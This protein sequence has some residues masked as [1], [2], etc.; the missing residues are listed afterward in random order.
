MPR[1]I[2]SGEVEERQGP[3]LAFLRLL[4][5]ADSA[6]PIGAVPHS[7]GLETLVGAGLLTPARVPAF[8]ETYLEESGVMEAVFCRQAFRLAAAT[9]FP[10]TRWLELNDRL[11]AL[12]VARESRTASAVMG[13]RLLDMV[14]G[15]VESPVLESALG[16]ARRAKSA[17]HHATAFGLSG[18]VLGFVE[19]TAAGA[20]LH[21]SI[22]GLV[23]ACQRLMPIGQSEA[24]RVVWDRK[25]AIL[26]AV[27]KAAAFDESDVPSFLPLLDWG[28]MEHPALATRL[29]IS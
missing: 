13:S 8:L 5:L 1:E 22:S 15:L 6:L 3:D 14:A 20:F 26:A 4:H 18:A 29:F 9:P 2:Q 21:Q 11:S 24:T 19:E 16:T 23:S 12:K 7:F 27:R 17:I 28:A 25:P 10:H